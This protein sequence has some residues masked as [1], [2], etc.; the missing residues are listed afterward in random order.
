M[1]LDVQFRLITEML[2]EIVIL[3]TA[4]SELVRLCLNFLMAIK[5]SWRCYSCFKD[6][7]LLCEAL[8][9]GDNT[10]LIMF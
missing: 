9:L 2:L 6:Y 4:F 8:M 7:L 3:M 10:L 5:H 1:A